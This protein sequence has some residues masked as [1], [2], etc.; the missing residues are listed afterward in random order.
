CKQ[1]LSCRG[2]LTRYDPVVASLNRRDTAW[3][4]PEHFGG[5]LFSF[6]K[7][8]ELRENFLIGDRNQCRSRRL[9]RP[10]RSAILSHHQHVEGRSF[11]HER[12]AFL[13]WQ[14]RERGANDIQLASR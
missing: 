14:S 12:F 7:V 10:A 3:S 13:F 6:E 4:E 1:G 2:T 5:L 8:R 9:G 11:G